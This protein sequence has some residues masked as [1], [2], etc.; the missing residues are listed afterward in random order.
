[1]KVSCVEDGVQTEEL[2]VG[3]G[4]ELGEHDDPFP[5]QSEGNAPG[6][7]DT[8]ALQLVYDMIYQEQ[9]RIHELSD[10][11]AQLRV[12]SESS[13]QGFAGLGGSQ[14]GLAPLGVAAVGSCARDTGVPEDT[15]QRATVPTVP[16]PPGYPVEMMY[17][18]GPEEFDGDPQVYVDDPVPL[19][20]APD[21]DDNDSVVCSETEEGH[22]SVGEW[23]T[24][25]GMSRGQSSGSGSSRVGGR[26]VA[27]AN[28]AASVG[29]AQARRS[30]EGDRDG[31]WE[32]CVLL[33]LV[34]ALFRMIGVASTWMCMRKRAYE[35][36]GISETTPFDPATPRLGGGRIEDEEKVEAESRR[37]A[38]LQLSPVVHVTV[39]NEILGSGG[40]LH[41]AV[42]AEERISG[43][44]CEGARRRNIKES[45]QEEANPVGP[46]RGLD[47]GRTLKRREDLSCT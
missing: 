6:P 37:D 30:I 18:Q 36:K 17:M 41:S 4:L 32:L 44:P 42:N 10:Q 29:S 13:S 47:Q 5:V 27:A 43:L 15:L 26:S 22:S 40:S 34:A 20:R 7:D 3:G 19:G 23:S 9:P 35:P 24:D 46:P 25:S 21:Q 33:G 39:R 12:L 31:S 28:I 8:R 45:S 38:H 16:K 11:A 2:S 14:E 1:M